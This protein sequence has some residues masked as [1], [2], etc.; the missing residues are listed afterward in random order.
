MLQLTQNLKTGKMDFSEVPVPAIGKGK[1]LV[2]NHYSVIS[3]GTEGGKVSTA[4]KGYIGKAKEKPAQV[5]QVIDTLKSEGIASTYRRVMNKLDAL[6]PL[7]YSA[8]GVVEAVGEGITRFKVGD[9][10]ASGGEGATH[11]E[12]GS[13]TENLLIKVPDNVDLKYAAY[14]TVA[15]IA[16]QGLRQADLAL[17]EN[18]VVIGVGVLGGVTVLL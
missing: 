8:S 10:V 9:R 2:R 18:C 4:R 3:A 11:A 5:R 13:V 15:A 7:G 14:S 17:G 1:V 12:V 16:I 6:S